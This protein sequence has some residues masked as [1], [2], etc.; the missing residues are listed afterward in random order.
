MVIANEESASKSDDEVDSAPGPEYWN[1]AEDLPF[2]Y[3]YHPDRG[4]YYGPPLPPWEH[5]LLESSDE[6]IS[7]LN[8][9]YHMYAKLII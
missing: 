2:G 3:H 9:H 8:D 6:G 5:I 7:H 1:V 4:L